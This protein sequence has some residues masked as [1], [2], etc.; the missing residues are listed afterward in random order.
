MKR[1]LSVSSVEIIDYIVFSILTMKC[2][3]ETLRLIHQIHHHILCLIMFYT[4]MI[5]GLFKQ[6]T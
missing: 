5:V 6:N 4:V 1:V 3:L 2:P